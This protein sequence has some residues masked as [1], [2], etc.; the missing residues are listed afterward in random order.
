MAAYT[1]TKP[2]PK[3]IN[4]QNR[5]KNSF[6]LALERAAGHLD[7]PKKYPLPGD[8]KSLEH[9]VYNLFSALPNRKQ[10]KIIDRL[11]PAFQTTPSKRKT[12]YGDLASISLSSTK[13]ITEQVTAIAVPQNFRITK[14]DLDEMKAPGKKQTGQP[15]KPGYSTGKKPVPQAASPLLAFTA[16]NL[17]CN[18]TSEIRKDE[19][20]L[21]AFGIDSANVQ[22]DVPS[23]FV[24]DFKKGDTLTLNRRLFTFSLDGS[25]VGEGNTFSTGLFLVEKDLLSNTELAGK[26][27]KLFFALS[28]TF[29]AISIALLVIGLAGGPVTEFMVAGA[30]GVSLFFYLLSRV[31]SFIADD[32]STTG[33]DTLVIEPPFNIGDRFDRTLSFEMCN[34]TGDLTTGRYSAAVHWEVVAV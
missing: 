15:K 4:L 24:G 23:F 10:R 14:T 7:D 19:I 6:N 27:E 34:G 30:M 32:F 20:S 21:A 31:F 3:L 29:V 17:T 33:F 26:L 11:K 22:Q 16:D 13:T 9:A 2:N 28:L 12:T 5:V 8:N 25:S 1:A 18:S